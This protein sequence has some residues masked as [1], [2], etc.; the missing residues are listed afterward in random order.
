MSAGAP[1]TALMLN[2][3]GSSPGEV[4]QLL[5]PVHGLSLTPLKP[6]FP[7]RGLFHSATIHAAFL[8]FC[9]YGPLFQSLN[10][11]PIVEERWEY[12]HLTPPESSVMERLP[13][14][15]EA[16]LKPTARASGTSAHPP[17]KV[18]SSH[19]VA[20]GAAAPVHRGAKPTLP[21]A[22]SGPQEVVSILPDS[23]NSVQTIRRPDL[24][25]PPKLK[26]PQ[27]LKPLVILPAEVPAI[28]E[29]KPVHPIVVPA[30]TLRIKDPAVEDPKVKVASSASLPALETS[31]HPLPEIKSTPQASARPAVI[32]LNAVTVPENAPSIVP[33][34]E[35]SG[36][37][38][39][40]AVSLAPSNVGASPSEVSTTSPATATT[41]NRQGDG[42]KGGAIN[43]SSETS[44]GNAADNLN[45]T[46]MTS[47]GNSPSSSNANDS[48]HAK[49]TAHGGG[50]G[51]RAQGTQGV[52]GIT[53]SGGMSRGGG[54][55]DRAIPYSADGITV[56]SS[57]TS[58]GASRDL[59]V[60]ARSETVYTVYIPMADAGGGPDWSMQYAI[61]GQQPSGS[62]MLT[63]PVAVKKVRAMVTGG[64]PGDS[65]TPIFFP[66]IISDNGELIVK[67]LPQMDVRAQQALEALRLWEFLP[68]H[69]N[70]SAVGTKVLIGV[71]T[72]SH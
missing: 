42:E 25:S 35:L 39:V 38:A 14:L 69:L 52:P 5:E 57:G 37:F 33:E 21:Q 4:S 49:A 10:A 47:A 44:I 20:D 32:V 15:A 27:L 46:G 43:R 11:P 64:S 9:L 71:A 48:S 41:T 66:A 53:I 19:G 12:M 29:A 61:L 13:Y 22:Y 67:P 56:I 72:V 34:A 17:P 8:S 40:H 26:F 24:V 3:Q 31:T 62:G 55:V 51:A 23:T 50:T 28:A 2:N 1:L 58:G 6:L 30:S 45:V 68:A 70:G 59:G 7:A 16:S 54:R 60:F 18:S 36:S 65:Q 63:P